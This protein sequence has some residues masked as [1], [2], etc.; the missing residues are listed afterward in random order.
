MTL[1]V[2]LSCDLELESANEDWKWIPHTRKPLKSGIIRGSTTFGSQVIAQP[3]SGRR[4]SWNY[5]IWPPQR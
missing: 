5:P 2:T 4:P 3:Y 1:N